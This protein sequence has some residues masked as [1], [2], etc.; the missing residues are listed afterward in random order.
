[1]KKLLIVST[2]VA[3]V[4]MSGAAFAANKALNV[5]FVSAFTHQTIVQVGKNNT[6]VN[7]AAFTLGTRQTIAQGGNGNQAANVAIGTIG[8]SQTTIQVTP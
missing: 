8:G 6:A 4:S 5:Q 7:A 1:M 2:A 3:V